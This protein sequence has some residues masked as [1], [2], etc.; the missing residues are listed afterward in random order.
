MGQVNNKETVTSLYSSSWIFNWSIKE[1]SSGNLDQ[2][3]MR[4]KVVM[5]DVLKCN[6]VPEF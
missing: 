3:D 1:T 5:K 6:N 2:N 4:F